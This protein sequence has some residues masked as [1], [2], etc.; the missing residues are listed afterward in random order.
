MSTTCSNKR[1]VA[2]IE[3]TKGQVNTVEKKHVRRVLSDINE[4]QFTEAVV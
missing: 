3:S 4:D 2:T 1:N